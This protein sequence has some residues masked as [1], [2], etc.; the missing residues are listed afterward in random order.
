MSEVES[1]AAVCANE[2]STVIRCAVGG[3]DHLPCCTRRGVPK[4][5][6]P[7]CQSVHQAATGADFVQCIPYI[8]QVF[9][10]LEEGTAELPPPVRALRAVEVGDGRVV[11]DWKTDD[12]N[13]TFGTSHFEVYYKKMEGNS[14]G[15]TVF[16]SDNVSFVFAVHDLLCLIH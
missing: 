10:C 7:L 4:S 11:V 13:D 3:R 2:F 16:S 8:G 9:T 15:T 14:T 12:M 5:C 6:Q 1:L